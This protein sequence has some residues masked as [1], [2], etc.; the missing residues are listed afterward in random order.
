[1]AYCNTVMLSWFFILSNWD[2]Y[3]FTLQTLTQNVSG[4]REKQDNNPVGM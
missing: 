1:M 4:V 2:F 3:W